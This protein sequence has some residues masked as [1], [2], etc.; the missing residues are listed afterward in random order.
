MNEDRSGEQSQHSLKHQRLGRHQGNHHKADTAWQALVVADPLEW[1][2]EP[3]AAVTATI[4]T[5]RRVPEAHDDGHDLDGRTQLD[6]QETH[7]VVLC[8][9]E[10]RLAVYL[11]LREGRGHVF[12]PRDAAH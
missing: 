2:T 5:S 9:H 10:Q 8:H 7:Q 4:T 6:V 1:T 3:P 11:L 12:T